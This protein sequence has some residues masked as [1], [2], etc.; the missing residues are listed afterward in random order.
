MTGSVW[1]LDDWF[2]FGTTELSGL[3]LRVWGLKVA[4]LRFKVSL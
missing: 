2:V 4:G 1:G 3:G